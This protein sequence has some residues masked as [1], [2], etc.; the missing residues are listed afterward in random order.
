MMESARHHMPHPRSLFALSLAL[1]L[2][3][4]MLA[5][6]PADGVVQRCLGRPATHVGTGDDDVLRG[7]SEADV[8]VGL[9]GDDRLLGRDGDDLFCGGRGAD[10]VR[11]GAGTDGA[12]GE[13]GNDELLGGGDDDELRGGGGNDRLDGQTGNDELDGGPGTDDCTGEALSNCESQTAELEVDGSWTGSTSQ[14]R[15]IS[16]E[17]VD[18]A[19]P[20]LTIAYGWLGPDC[21]LD[22]ATTIEFP[23]PEEIVGN[24]FDIDVSP[25]SLTLQING[26][27]S[28]ETE[29]EGTFSAS[30]NGGACPGN[31]HGTW[32][33]SRA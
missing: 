3:F 6:T 19:L 30:D 15:A 22:T 11:G 10:L 28:S 29:A 25:R 23:T 18:H 32:T 12:D 9:A 13:G 4:T 24:Q 7:T 5:M 31:V 14:A 16:F 17:V 8:F 33:A 20:A 27:F 21:I 26:T 2:L 1:S